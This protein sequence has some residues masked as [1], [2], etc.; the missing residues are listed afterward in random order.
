M[1]EI[2]GKHSFILDLDIDQR[3]LDPDLDQGETFILDLDL[4]LSERFILDLDL[5]L[6]LSKTIHT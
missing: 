4:D 3:N 2:G 5:N 6:D 1:T